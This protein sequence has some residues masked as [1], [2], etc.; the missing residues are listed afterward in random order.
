MGTFAGL[1]RDLGP[2]ILLAA[3]PAGLL[4]WLLDAQAGWQ[5]GQVVVGL[6]AFGLLALSVAM[7]AHRSGATRFGTANRVTLVRTGLVCLAGGALW[8]GEQGITPSWS[9][10]ALIAPALLLDAL[11]GPVARRRG[12]ATTFGARFDLEIDTLL[13]LVL[14]ALVWQSGRTGAWVLAIGLARYVF[15][16][17][18]LAVP[19]LRRSL[20]PSRRR[21][22]ICGLQGAVL[23]AC[24]LPPTA[25]GIARVAAAG[26][27][28]ALLASFAI[29]VRRLL[30]AGSAV[31]S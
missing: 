9:L 15:L 24:L 14:A 27:L 2:S 29:D 21:R 4:A 31:A 23:W 18:G 6:T 16:A 22:V 26:A 5:T 10:A 20:P 19:A 8:T 17:A 12:E 1:S 3:A 7:A 25:P 13:L 28:V 30:R 11:D